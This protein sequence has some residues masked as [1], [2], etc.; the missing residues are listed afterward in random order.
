MKSNL[1]YCYSVNLHYFLMALGEKYIS[2]SINK[3]TKMRYWTFQKSKILDQK[4]K[5]YNS[6]KHEFV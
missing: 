4:I 1:Y 3:N 2:S 6:V 5:L